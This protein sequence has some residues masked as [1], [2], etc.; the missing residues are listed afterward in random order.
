[1]SVPRM[2]SNPRPAAPSAMPATSKTVRRMRICALVS[3]NRSANAVK[4]RYVRHPGPPRRSHP[5]DR[6]AAVGL[7]VAWTIR[8]LRERK[9]HA[10]GDLDR[11]RARHGQHSQR[12]MQNNRVGQ[13]RHDETQRRCQQSESTSSPPRIPLA[14]NAKR[15][16]T[17][18]PARKSRNDS[19]DSARI[20]SS[21]W[22]HASTDGADDHAGNDFHHWRGNGTPGM[23]PS[24]AMAVATA[25]AIT[26]PVDMSH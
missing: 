12:M 8:R 21:G 17:S 22:T 18:K 10:R 5:A 2:A 15:T 25:N 4:W 11:R 9:R 7:P 20:V 3:A 6:E 16:S 24:S 23:K 1:M 13:N 26:R 19:P 14:P